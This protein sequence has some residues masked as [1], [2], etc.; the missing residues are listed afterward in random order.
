MKRFWI[1]MVIMSLFLL[2][3]CDEAKRELENSESYDYYMKSFY[4]NNE[5]IDSTISYHYMEYSFSN[6][7]IFSLQTFQNL[8]VIQ[9]WL[10]T[11]NKIEIVGVIP[12]YDSENSI[13]GFNIALRESEIAHKYKIGITPSNPNIY[14]YRAAIYL[15]ENTVEEILAHY[16]VIFEV[17]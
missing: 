5:P 12:F 6:D 13:K 11:N 7:K 10:S 1:V 17:D 14:K 16:I 8:D 2:S 15:P 3:G 9:E 4:I